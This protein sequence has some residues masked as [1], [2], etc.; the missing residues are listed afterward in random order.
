M[1]V[2]R[3]R[4]APHVIWLY[5]GSLMSLRQTN[6]SMV[7]LIANILAARCYGEAITQWSLELC[8][9]P[10]KARRFAPTTRVVRT[11]PS[12]LDAACAQLAG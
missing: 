9:A 1:S 3:V 11:W 2:V 10:C 12:G 4:A 5:H 6:L 8:S 7:R